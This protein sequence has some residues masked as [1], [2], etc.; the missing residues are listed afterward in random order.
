MNIDYNKIALDYVSH[1]K[2]QPHV[3]DNLISQ[4][5]VK[6]DDKVLEIGCGSGN[7]ISSVKSSVN[8]SCWGID[9]S[10]EMLSKAKEKSD[11]VEFG[12]GNAESLNFQ[13]KFFNLVFS[14]D[15][16]HHLTNCLDYF[17][18]AF[19]VLVQGGRI[20]TVTDSEWIIRNRQ[21]LAKYYPDIVEVELKSGV[22]Q[23]NGI[24]YRER[25]WG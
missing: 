10:T 14:V 19:R 22:T 8:C 11:D 3:L 4:C 5:N 23:K 12:I 6:C 13:D 18:E 24:K 1:R 7:Y 20:C 16:I 9:P 25:L 21:P 17:Q 15:V 2:P